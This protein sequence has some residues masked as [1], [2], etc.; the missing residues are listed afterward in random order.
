MGTEYHSSAGRAWFQQHHHGS[1]T[2]QNYE[3]VAE[4][5]KTNHHDRTIHLHQSV[6][7]G[8]ERTSIAMK[9]LLLTIISK[10]A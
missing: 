6:T 1:V 7:I 4:I 3:P 5:L 2:L 8:T 9:G 10:S